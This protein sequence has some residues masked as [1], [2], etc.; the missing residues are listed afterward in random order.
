MSSS[1]EYS[2][3]FAIAPPASVRPG[4]PFS[5]PVV[6]AVRPIGAASS[7]PLQQLGAGAS[8]RD[9]S[10]TSPSGGLTGTV[11]T[12]VRSRAGNTTNGY[13]R[14][15]PLRI[16]TPGKYKLRVTLVNN[17]SSGVTVRGFIESS[18]IHVHAGAAA[19]QQPSK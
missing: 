16:T 6:V 14:L 15:G 3:T 8:L 10:G 19:S 7:D 18:V 1:R 12:S 9:E 11:S 5:L 13:A 17:T 4:V 2:L